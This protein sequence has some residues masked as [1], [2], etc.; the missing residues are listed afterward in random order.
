V[1]GLFERVT[2]ISFYA[3]RG[4]L[5]PASESVH[6]PGGLRGFG[7]EL[8]F[9]VGAVTRPAGVAGGNGDAAGDS[10][11]LAWTERRV[12][13]NGAG[14]DTVDLYQVR[15][16]PA[17]ELEELWTF[18]L[19]I[20]Y[21]QLSGF[22]A[23]DPD[24]ELKGSVRELPAVT[25]YAD[26]VATGA[27]FGLRSGLIETHAL[28]LYADDGGSLVEGS[29]QAFQLGAAVGWAPEVKNVFPFLEVAWNARSFP[30]IEWDTDVLP[31]AAPRDLRLSG[32]AVSVG[33]QV[34]LQ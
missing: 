26:H 22:S 8:L 19:A 34:P 16:P 23:R 14:T 29:A 13:R 6:A 24:V 18:E 10:V 11:V 21:G 27:Y 1:E 12:T 7:V 9:Q 17:P 4:E 30:S 5:R 31:P 20:G 33:L 25:V 3:S 32:W 2:D 15:E 28:R